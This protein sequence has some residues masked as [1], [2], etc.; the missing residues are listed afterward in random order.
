MPI[1]PVQQKMRRFLLA[2]VIVGAAGLLP[3]LLLLEHFESVWQ[4]VPLVILTAVLVASV[5]V[6]A[7]PDPRSMLAFRAV[8]GLCV[9]AALAG[10]VLHGKGNLEWALERDDSLRG[11]PLIWKVLRGATPLLAPGA[12][13]QIGL[14][15]LVYT[16]RH[17]ALERGHHLEPET[18]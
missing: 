9:V 17:P 12:M 7:R 3:E 6:W 5:L 14:L 1:A 8:M 15:G 4:F 11:W 18:K 2:L 16:Y 13:A 10:L